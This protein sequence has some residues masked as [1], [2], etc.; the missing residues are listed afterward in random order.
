MKTIKRFLLIPALLMP[1]VLLM[2]CPAKPP[3]SPNA[4][5]IQNNWNGQ[6][7]TGYTNLITSSGFYV[8]PYPG[9]TMSSVVL[10]FLV[11]Q[12]GSYNYNLTVTDSAYNG[13]VI[14]TAS[15][16]PV[17]L[18]ST[19]LY[20]PVTFTLSGDPGVTKGHTVAFAVNA[21]SGPGT[22]SYC[23]Q[24]SNA[25]NVNIVLTIGTSPP[26]GTAQGTGVAVVIDGNS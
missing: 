15:S 21:T 19:A 20:Q 12:T 24:A 4:A 14:G 16:G 9:S 17:S 18:S 10:W 13:S 3:T 2:G 6:T 23:P 5:L 25:N 8:Q 7:P 22:T 11:N 26:L 1:V